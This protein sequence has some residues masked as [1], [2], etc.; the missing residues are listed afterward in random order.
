MIITSKIK[1]DLALRGVTAPVNAVQDD[2]YSRNLEITL[3]ANGT[4]WAPPSGTTAVV[5]YKKP[6][7][8]GGNYDTLPDGTA[9]CSISGN[10]ATV[11]LAP[12]VLTVPGMVYLSVGL[13][14]AEA[15][16]HTFAV[17]IDVQPNPGIDVASEDYVNVSGYG[18]S[19]YELDL[20][21]LVTVSHSEEAE[22]T[23]VTSIVDGAALMEAINA[24]HVIRAGVIESVPLIGKYVASVLLT[25]ATVE[26]NDDGSFCA[27]LSGKYMD[28]TYRRFAGAYLYVRYEDGAYT[29]TWC[30]LG[31]EKEAGATVDEVLS[32]LPITVSED[33][34]TDISGLRRLKSFDV[35]EDGTTL[36]FNYTLEGDESHTDV[37]TFDENGYPVSI[38]A[39]GFEAA[40][41]WTVV[42]EAES[43]D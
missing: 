33:G 40:G 20:T 14:C 8:T 15:E 24:G 38:V 18:C 2:K 26:Q 13:V 23:D 29:I 19:F 17:R 25:T 36:T 27:Y 4:P 10:V 11:A 1:M 5:R 30:D 21:E 34:Y 42:E 16:I 41:T 35:T 3:L 12:Q 31:L 32:E 28:I 6:D 43:G 37:I 22:S 9:A 7:G 39:D